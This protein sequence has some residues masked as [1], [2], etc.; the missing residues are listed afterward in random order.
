MNTGTAQSE[1]LVS[2]I[3]PAFRCAGV[4]GETI[5]SVLDQT[6]AHWELLIA[7]DCSPDNSAAIIEQW[8]RL[9]KRIRLIRMPTNGGPALARNAA[10]E[11]ASGRWLAFLDSDDLWLP[12]K[13]EHSLRFASEHGAAF[14]FTGFRRMAAGGDRIGHYIRP[15]RTLTYRQ[16]LGNTAIATSTVM[17][18]RWAVGQVAMRN[19]YYD[20]FD[21]WL[22]IL[23]AGHI[24]YGLDEDLMR[25]RVMAQSVSRGKH[26]S[27]LMV[28][29]S[30][31]ELEQMSLPMAAWYFS[32]YAVRGMLKYSRL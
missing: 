29:R 2:I 12:D 10:I 13:L 25:Y 5:Q 7:E 16:L 17:L 15:P 23:K 27:A 30:Y 14:I 18:D 11:A 3:T 24:A 20:D 21:C 8:C 4:V 19:T 28:W 22:R 6:H 31:R 26:R 32:Q 9:D 1:F